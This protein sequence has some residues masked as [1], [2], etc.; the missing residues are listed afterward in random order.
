MQ[1][2][3]TGIQ[4]KLG[5]QA[6]S[7]RDRFDD[8]NL[9]SFLKLLIAELQ[10]QDPMDPVGNSEILQQVSQIREIQSNQQMIDTFESL[11]LGQNMS[12]ATTL[13]GQN[14]IALTDD[15][16]M[17]NGRVDRVTVEEGAPKLHVGE[18]T[19]SLKNI[20]EIS[21]ETAE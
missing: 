18:H 2:A 20:S 16:E 9:D 5:P 4:G 1:T 15:S 17:V 3:T 11:T 10:N 12:T 21:S 8:L 19:I 6:S 7:G 13:L 14:V